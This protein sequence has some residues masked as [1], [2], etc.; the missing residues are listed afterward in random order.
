[1]EEKGAE[2]FMACRRVLARSTGPRAVARERVTH[3]MVTSLPH[4]STSHYHKCALSATI[5]FFRD[6]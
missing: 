4:H 5:P 6:N 1:M 2:R 3:T